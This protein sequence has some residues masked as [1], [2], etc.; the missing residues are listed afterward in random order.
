VVEVLTATG[1]EDTI[2]IQ[3]EGRLISLNGN[4]DWL[5]VES[6]SQASSILGSK[7][8]DIGATDDTL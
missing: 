1:G 5:L 6:L 4:R 2:M 7:G 8:I 3:L